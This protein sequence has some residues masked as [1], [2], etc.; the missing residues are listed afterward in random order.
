MKKNGEERGGKNQAFK[1]EKIDYL[2]LIFLYFSE[3][4]IKQ[5]HHKNVC[6]KEVWPCSEKHLLAF[7]HVR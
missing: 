7:P 5:K 1:K 6:K 4:G 2:K 3:K